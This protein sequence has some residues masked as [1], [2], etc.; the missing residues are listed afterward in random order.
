M[1]T[2]ARRV[3]SGLA[4]VHQ[5]VAILIT[6]RRVQVVPAALRQ[7]LGP[8][9]VDG[10]DGVEQAVQ[11]VGPAGLGWDG[12]GGAAAGRGRR[13]RG[14]QAARVGVMVAAARVHFPRTGRTRSLAQSR[15]DFSG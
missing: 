12:G 15:Q 4:R 10:R 11:A 13:T 5:G 9:L 1:E 7:L 14:R 8:R 2:Q 3:L 6:A